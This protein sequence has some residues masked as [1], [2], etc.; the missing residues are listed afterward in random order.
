MDGSI[1]Q[2]RLSFSKRCLLPGKPLPPWIAGWRRDAVKINFVACPSE[3]K[4]VA[5]EKL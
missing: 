3:K 2:H 4:S 5:L 1:G